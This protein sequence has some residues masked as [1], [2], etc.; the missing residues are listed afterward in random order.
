MRKIGAVNI[1]DM[2]AWLLVVTATI[3][4][5][6]GIPFDSQRWLMRILCLLGVAWVGA[7][8]IHGGI[9]VK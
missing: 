5:V 7:R 8:V 4:W 2:L 6:S 9:Y 3:A 1:I